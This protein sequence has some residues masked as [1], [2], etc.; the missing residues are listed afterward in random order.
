[1]NAFTKW[2]EDNKL[3]PHK[4]KIGAAPAHRLEATEVINQGEIM[5]SGAT[6]VPRPSDLKP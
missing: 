6:S 3:P 5:L 2:T 4:V 1:M